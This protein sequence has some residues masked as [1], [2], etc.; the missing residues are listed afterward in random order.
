[1][2]KMERT[3]NDIV[4]EFEEQEG[5]SQ[6]VEEADGF[7]SEADEAEAEAR[8]ERSLEDEAE[9]EEENWCTERGYDFCGDCNGEDEE[10]QAC[11]Y[12]KNSQYS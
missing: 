8:Y 4:R 7:L 6:W 12:Y 9:D 5:E 3:I 11:P 1:M 10:Y 2:T